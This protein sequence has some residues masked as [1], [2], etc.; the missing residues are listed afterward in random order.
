MP[1]WTRLLFHQAVEHGL[2][3]SAGGRAGRRGAWTAR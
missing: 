2:S 3:A 1:R